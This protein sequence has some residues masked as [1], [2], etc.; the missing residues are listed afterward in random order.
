MDPY[1]CTSNLDITC[2]F[3][4]GRST[5]MPIWMDKVV[6]RF[7]DL[8]FQTTKF[9]ILIPDTPTGQW[10]N[11]HW[12]Q[13]GIYNKITKDYNFYYSRRHYRHRDNWHS[14]L[15]TYSSLNADIVGKAGSYRQNVSVNV[16]NPSITTG[17]L[18]YICICTH[19]SLFENGMTALSAATLAMTT[20]ATF[21]GVD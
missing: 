17:D 14:S 3:E 5:H 12:Y 13:I 11:Y 9:H 10:Y 4:L 20:P 2:T 1:P 18:S 15:S 6:V 8:S 21:S 16:Y 7:K 19:W